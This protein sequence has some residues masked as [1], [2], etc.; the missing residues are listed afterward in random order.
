MPQDIKKGENC[1]INNNECETGLE[2]RQLDQGRSCHTK[3][4]EPVSTRS[5]GDCK[6]P[7]VWGPQTACVEIVK[8]GEN[9]R[10]EYTE[11]ETGLHCLYL[12]K[13]GSP[14]KKCTDIDICEITSDCDDGFICKLPPDSNEII[15]TDINGKIL[16]SCVKLD[17]G[18]PDQLLIDLFSCCDKITEYKKM[19]IRLAIVMSAITL[20]LGYSMLEYNL[21][22][23]YFFL[24]YVFTTVV[25]LLAFLFSSLSL[26]FGAGAE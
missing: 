3:D 21:G 1:N 26:V 5:Q 11:C 22:I 12:N 24:N 4:G 23:I 8:N 6:E 7:N 9:C 17:C 2:C 14:V 18:F 10:E 15:W 19:I 20:I 13:V 25:Y 16:K